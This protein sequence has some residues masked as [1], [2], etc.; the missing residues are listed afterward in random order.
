[1]DWLNYA[2]KLAEADPSEKCREMAQMA[3]ETIASF[4]SLR[5]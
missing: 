2:L 5:D 4:I 3:A 1:M